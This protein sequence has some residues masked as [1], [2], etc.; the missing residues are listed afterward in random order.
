MIPAQHLRVG[1]NC[2]RAR[3]ATRRNPPGCWGHGVDLP[4]VAIVADRPTEEAILLLHGTDPGPQPPK[5]GGCPRPTST[6]IDKCLEEAPALAARVAE[7][8]RLLVA[9]VTPARGTS[10]LTIPLDMV[11][12]T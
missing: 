3:S 5:H 7:P 4:P 6:R 9:L 10:L 1:G 12:L 11:A 8:R 2:Q